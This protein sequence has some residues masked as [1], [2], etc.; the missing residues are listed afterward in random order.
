VCVHTHTRLARQ[1]HK[2]I[3]KLI[4]GKHKERT[5]K[6]RI[7]KFSWWETQRDNQKITQVVVS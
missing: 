1:Q 2:R 7:N 3:N 4:G 5:K 6:K